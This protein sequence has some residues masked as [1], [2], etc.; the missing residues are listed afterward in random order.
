MTMTLFQ[1]N[2][3]NLGPV[4]GPGVW[5]RPVSVYASASTQLSTSEQITFLPFVL[6]QYVA[7][8]KIGL[9]LTTAGSTG[10]QC[11]LGLYFNDPS[12]GVPAGLIFDC[13]ALMLD[14]T[15][16]S[17]G[18]I[19]SAAVPGSANANV[20]PGVYWVGCAMK[21]SGIATQPAVARVTGGNGQFIPPLSNGSDII[22]AWT[23]SY[24]ASAAYAALPANAPAVT[25]Y[26]GSDIPMTMLM[27]S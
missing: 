9:Y 17:A 19:V 6:S 11:D 1:S 20:A 21:A 22:N 23:R 8:S 16:G 25:P 15:G 5:I 13:G 27:H 2:G 24:Q 7:I 14:G 18:G 4:W 26:T 3:S 12:L 10:A